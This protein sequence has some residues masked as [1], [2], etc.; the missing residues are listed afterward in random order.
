LPRRR[1]RRGSMQIAVRTFGGFSF[2]V[3]VL[4]VAGQTTD[5]RLK[6]EINLY[7]YSGVA[8]AVVSRAE[9]EAARIYEFAGVTMEWRTCPT[10]AEE[11]KQNTTCELAAAPTRFTLRLL[12]DEMGRRFPL[13]NDIYGFALLSLNGGF[14][15]TASVFADRVRKAATGQEGMG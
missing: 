13:N 7:N 12:S 3:S 10:N 6:I 4:T 9:Q 1:G 14:G 15:V 5:R 2:L 11:L 8:Q